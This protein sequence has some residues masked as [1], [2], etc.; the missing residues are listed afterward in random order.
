VRDFV[1]E[2]ER[3][4]AAVEMALF[5]RGRDHFYI[6]RPTPF[7]ALDGAVAG[8]ILVLQDV[9]YLRDQEARREQ[10]MATLSH[11]L[12]PPLTSLRMAVELLRRDAE[13][14]RTELLET[15]HEDV[16][17]LE[18]VAQRLLDVCARGR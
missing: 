1:A 7:R 14:S 8:L 4:H 2:P 3:E 5:L 13:A 10:L 12:R 9:T 18:D 15:A 6:L 16:M 11:E 17:R